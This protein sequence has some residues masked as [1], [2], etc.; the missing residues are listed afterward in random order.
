VTLVDTSVWIAHLRATLP[1]LRALLESD[2]VLTHLFVIGE[3]ASG[4]L[5]N[6]AEILDLFAR[7][8][9]A[10]VAEHHEVMHLVASQRLYRRGIGWFDAH[11]L[12]S[13]LLSQATLWTLDRP[14]ARVAEA[15]GAARR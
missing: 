7:L 5:K 12:A 13:A 8:P 3:L 9:Q 4:N 14:L 11:L 2:Q 15:L 10:Q 6:R 1:G